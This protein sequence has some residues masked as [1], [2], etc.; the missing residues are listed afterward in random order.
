M[1]NID[2]SIELKLG[3]DK[4]VSIS[5]WIGKTK[6]EFVKIFR[7][8]QENVSENN[9]YDTL[10][11]PYINNNEQYYSPDEIQYI[12]FS[13]RT[14]S[15]NENIVFS[16]DCKDCEEDIA[17][18]AELKEFFKYTPS[19]FPAQIDRIKWKDIQ[20]NSIKAIKEKYPD[21]LKSEID[22]LL[23]IEAVDDVKITSYNQVQEIVDNMTLSESNKLVS[24]Y[25]EAKSKI[26]LEAI[27]KCPH[28][29]VEHTYY[30]DKIPT[31]FDPILP[32]KK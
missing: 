24:D 17:V 9:I 23:H 16:I 29:N 27:I 5:P 20:K 15:T 8:K 22:L 30:F 32:R 2:D 1:F 28:C 21:D 19:V 18:D 31:L 14:I 12:L 4:T 3:D 7:D 6:K 11:R 26:S 13:I 10:I 25:S